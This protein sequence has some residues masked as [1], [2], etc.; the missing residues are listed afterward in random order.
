MALLWIETAPAV[1]CITG[2]T[3]NNPDNVYTINA[4]GTVLDTRT[5]LMWKRCTEGNTWNAATNGCSGEPTTFDW[6]NALSL[7]E[8]ST[9]ANYT[10]WRLPNRKELAS[11]IENCRI[12]QAINDTVFP[13]THNS[14]YWSSSPSADYETMSWQ[15][16]FADGTTD[17]GVRLGA[18][19]VRLVRDNTASSNYLLTV[20]RTGDGKVTSNP[21]G[22][23]CSSTATLCESAY[24]ANTVVT[25]TAVELNGATFTGWGG[26]CSGTATTCTV[27]MSA[28]QSVTADFTAVTNTYT[29]TTTVSGNGSITSSPAG[30]DCG[31]DCSEA[32]AATSRVIL[33]ATPATGALF[34]GWAG[35][36]GGSA[37][38]CTVNMTAAQSVT[39]IF[40]TPMLLVN[41]SANGQVTSSPAGI[42]CGGGNSDCTEAVAANT[43]V[44]LTATPVAGATFTGWSGACSGTATTCTVTANQATTSV[45]ATFAANTSTYSLTT[46][47]NGIGSVTSNPA[48]ITC[49]TDCSET[50][51]ANTVVT[52]T[53]TPLLNATFTGW[54]GAC[55][56]TA[57]TCTVTMSAAQSVTATF[58]ANTSTYSL[59]TSVNGIGSVTS[60][61]AGITCGTDCSETFAANT[62]VTLTATP[63][64]NATFTGWGGAC[65]GTATTCTVTMSAAQSVTATFAAPLALLSV[66]LDQPDL[67]RVTADSG[68]LDCPDVCSGSYPRGSQV[69]LTAQAAAGAVFTGWDGGCFGSEPECIVT[70]DAAQAVRARFEPLTLTV[71]ISG[72]GHVTSDLDDLDCPGSCIVTYPIET[73]LI[74]T[75]TPTL[76][77][78]L[79][80][81]GG[82]CTGTADCQVTVG[83]S[84]AV[85]ANFAELSNPYQLSN[86]LNGSVESGIGVVDGWVCAATTVSLQVDDFPAFST[87][88]GAERPDSAALCGD[89]A[90]GFAAAINWADYGDGEHTLTVL[91]DGQI[92]TQVTVDV[93]TLGTAYLKGAAAAA[94]VANF[95]AAGIST[96]LLWSEPHQNFV[97]TGST[98]VA[99][100]DLRYAARDA[101]ATL[102]NWESPLPN[103]FESGNTLLRGW[104]C[105]A[106]QLTATLDGVVTFTL[107][108]GSERE[109]TQ[110]VCGDS[111]N[112]YALAINWNDFTD[113]QHQ[114]T[115]NINDLP[116]ETRRFTVATPGGLGVILGVQQQQRVTNF[117]LAGDALTLRWSEPHQNFRFSSY[118]PRASERAA[119][120]WQITEIY[121]ATL[122]YAPDSEGLRYWVNK[123]LD[124]HWT[125]TS[126]AQSFFD[127]EL[128]QVRYPLDAGDEALVDA[129]YENIFNRAADLEGK[130]YW[131]AQL[132]AGNTARHE[133]IIAM[134]NGGW[135]ND[136]AADDMMRFRHLT[137]VGLA[138]AD[139]QD[140]RGIIYTALSPAQQAQLRTAG[141]EVLEGV[142]ADVITRNAAIANIPALLDSVMAV[143]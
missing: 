6:S 89:T 101:T 114:I 27:T 67:G 26:A 124:D 12:D 30:I 24:S 82:A 68:D 48:G 62:V 93:V 35:N 140:E 116:V 33:T 37:T 83:G 80:G 56:G 88:Y 43:A 79:L 72:A 97:V 123:L 19:V 73:T 40:T 92:T 96:N 131:L 20:T 13:N 132:A 2:L 60:N 77:W 16:H 98:Q 52:L 134:I 29:L 141:T 1:T 8:A 59:T 107:P 108:Y 4:N 23:E 75:A 14:Y 133:L 5:G 58:A 21:A 94:T 90:N 3:A 31:A 122:G 126:V 119:L 46:S 34:T 70:M 66:T 125:P 139:A 137:Q 36:C 130:T 50:F 42:N 95:P 117:P 71:T 86:P 11:L 85:T 111:H 78:Q 104:A 113:G 112:G 39:A 25:L 55:S 76:G 143:E 51:A 18:N 105:D 65:S 17:S 120:A 103:G 69:T 138:F 9:W 87:A 22:I 7:A 38:T 99:A 100:P 127:N 129:L 10:D 136:N 118:Q 49:G 63:L 47:V 32:F 128:V 28:A 102:H 15:I 74:L 91:A 121:I 45:T 109:D 64:L 115:L 106:A 84:T 81:W 54:G 53:A 57:T 41:V 142:T 61:P 110:P 135:A 44:T